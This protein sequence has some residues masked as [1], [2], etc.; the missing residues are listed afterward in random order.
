MTGF[1]NM[2]IAELENN[3]RLSEETIVKKE[4]LRQRAMH[5]ALEAKQK[6]LPIDGGPGTTI[7]PDGLDLDTFV[8][9]LNPTAMD[10]LKSL[11]GIG[12]GK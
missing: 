3:I 7:S 1:E 10:K 2:T 4:R 12:G 9:N 6:L 11:L 5:D 8:K